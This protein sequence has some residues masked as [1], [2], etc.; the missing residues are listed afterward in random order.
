[1]IQE[2][3]MPKLGQTVEE[4]KVEKWHKTEGDAVTRGEIILEVTTD[5]ATLEVESYY[6]GYLKK[7]IFGEGETVPVGT[8]IAFVADKDEEI[9]EELIEKARATIP[10]AEGGEGSPVAA[11]GTAERIEPAREARVA[12]G[13]PTPPERI[14]ASPRA[15]KLARD[16]KVP[17]AVLRG[18]G[19]GGRIIERD[20]KEYLEKLKEVF[21]TPSATEASYKLAVNLLAV[22]GTGEGG[23]VTVG[24]VE[25]MA[26]APA[27]EAEV[28]LSD[29]RAI[30]AKRM[31]ESKRTVPHFYLFIDVDM[32]KLVSL[33]QRLNEESP[34]R[35]SFNDFI[36]RACALSLREV[37]EMNVRWEGDRIVR[38]GEV[39]IALAVAVEDGL[40]TPVVRNADMKSLSEIAGETATLIEKARSRRLSPDDYAGGCL[41]ISNL[42][43][44]GVTAVVPIINPGE[45]AI[46]GVGAIKPQPVALNGGIYI[47]SM[48]C[49]TLSCDHRA[50]DGVI[51]SRFL[52]MV[53]EK[54]ESPET[55]T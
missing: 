41:T 44:F 43:M 49:L 46:L 8:I 36:I 13:E 21:A 47:R 50:I 31:S 5:K 40:I 48:M 53:R 42:G 37:S 1:M 17:L 16:H 54:L 35:I 10:K 4:A 24:D 55:L 2:V 9:P 12:V 14:T 39:N 26:R 11:E 18:S 27:V 45:P 38:R 30:I 29:M 3:I 51:G 22:E 6:E 19:A 52:S 7:I 33:R 23:R 34:L 15:R 20:V 28:P 32:T 25:R